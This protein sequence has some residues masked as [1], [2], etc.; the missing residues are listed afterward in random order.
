M[1]GK[2]DCS[3]TGTMTL[4]HLTVGGTSHCHGILSL[5][6]GIILTSIFLYF[7]KPYM[8]RRASEQGQR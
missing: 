6:S 2:A 3:C 4:P 1:T 8:I 5:L 7:P